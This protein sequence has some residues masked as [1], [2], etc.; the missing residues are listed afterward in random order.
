[1]NKKNF[2]ITYPKRLEKK[3][4]EWK[5]NHCSKNEHLFDEV[6]NYEDHYLVCDACELEVHIKKIVKR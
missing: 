6:Y 1:M 2:G 5:K 4:K 3:L